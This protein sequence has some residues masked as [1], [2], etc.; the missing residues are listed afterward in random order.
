MADLGEEAFSSQMK[1]VT[2][3]LRL[4][5]E[6]MRNKQLDLRYGTK[7]QRRGILR[8]MKDFVGGI[9]KKVYD[10]TFGRLS[11]NGKDYGQLD[12]NDPAVAKL[13]ADTMKQMGMDAMHEDNNLLFS[14]SDVAKIL[15]FSKMVEQELGKKIEHENDTPEKEQSQEHGQDQERQANARGWSDYPATPE[16]IDLTAT[17]LAADEGVSID[18]IKKDFSENPSIGELQ[19]ALEAKGHDTM[20]IQPDL[21]NYATPEQRA[22][23]DMLKD[24]G[25]IGENE[26]MQLGKYPS[27]DKASE[28]LENHADA[29]KMLDSDEISNRAEAIRS[30]DGMDPDSHTKQV[31]SWKEDLSAKV[32]NAF[33]ASRDANGQPNLNNF[34]LQCNLR[35]IAVQFANDGEL[36]FTDANQHHKQVRADNLDPKFSRNSEA[37]KGQKMSKPLKQKQE[38]IIKSTDQ[39]NHE[40]SRAHD[41]QDHGDA[42]ELL[43]RELKARKEAGAHNL[44]EQKKNFPPGIFG[45][46]VRCASCGKILTKGKTLRKT[47]YERTLFCPTRKKS[48]SHCKGAFISE[49][50]LESAILH[51]LKNLADRY[52][53]DRVQIGICQDAQ[54]VDLIQEKNRLKTAVELIEKEIT[55][56][57][58]RSRDLYLKRAI[59]GMSIDDFNSAL[60]RI[61][62]DVDKLRLKSKRAS[63]ELLHLNESI[64]A[65]SIRMETVLKAADFNRLDK[66]KVSMLIESVYVH[67]RDPKSG[68]QAIDITWKF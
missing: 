45:K 66:T 44:H 2:T 54:A 1:V 55:A 7:T 39:R 35:G 37:F 64:A 26:L 21:K 17:V 11:R 47:G 4:L 30:H 53:D 63:S 58:Q 65:E 48:P 50:H 43:R 34:A 10:G 51:E 24:K 14:T 67:K 49:K 9:F 22:Q 23:L 3:F 28:V 62:N 5:E 41:S 36:L 61:R 60:S 12:L 68:T 38:E 13:F 56:Y 8:R 59:D 29:V 6:L 31:E 19:I 27:Q 33:E 46:E 40:H 32:G 52:S 15:A 57:E 42:H 16:Q 20:A 18:E 25:I